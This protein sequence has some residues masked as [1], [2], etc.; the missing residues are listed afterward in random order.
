MRRIWRLWQLDGAKRDADPLS[1]CAL[2]LAETLRA[3]CHLRGDTPEAGATPLEL[4]LR[5]GTGVVWGW[6]V[7]R[8]GN[9]ARTTAETHPAGHDH[10]PGA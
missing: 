5:W 10:G 7:Q 9:R 2:Q 4:E 3:S 6:I 1:V 8:H